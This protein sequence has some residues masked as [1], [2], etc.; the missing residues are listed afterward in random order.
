VWIRWVIGFRYGPRMVPPEEQMSH[1]SLS[2]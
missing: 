2:S 1:I